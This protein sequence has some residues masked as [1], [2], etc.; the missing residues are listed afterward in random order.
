VIE[1]EQYSERPPRFEY[2]LT[3][4]GKDLWPVL[5]HL[6]QWGD[7]YYCAPGGPPNRIEHVD[8]G[9]EPDAHLM[10]DRC[11]AALDADNVQVHA[12]IPA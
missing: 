9:G 6:V 12:L 1:R 2:K 3:Q 10:C 5:A 11:G 8:C 4:K 7:A